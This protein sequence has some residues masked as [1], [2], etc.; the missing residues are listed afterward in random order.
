MFLLFH[1]VHRALVA[2]IFEWVAISSS[3]GPCFIRILHYDPS[4]LGGLPDMTHSFTDLC[5]P[6][7]HGKAAI[8]EVENMCSQGLKADVIE[9]GQVVE[10][11]T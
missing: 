7:H 4:V 9:D 2:R 11:F 8:H 6:L 10:N 5:K 3:S 1:A